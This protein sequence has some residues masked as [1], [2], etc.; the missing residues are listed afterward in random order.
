LLARAY[1]KKESFSAIIKSEREQ[2]ICGDIPIFQTD[3]AAK[4]L[5]L[6]DGNLVDIFENSAL[7]LVHQK[8]GNSGTEDFEFQLKL[9]G[10]AIK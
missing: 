4:S 1:L 3:T 7:D 2:M 9:I 8:I 6:P 5:V 10:N